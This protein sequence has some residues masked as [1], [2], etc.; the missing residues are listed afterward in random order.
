MANWSDL[1]A[2]VAEV[3]K[4]NGN[5]EITGQVLQNVLNSIISNV[6]QNATFVGV[7]TPT[8]NPGAPDGNVFY[9]AGEGI[10]T[11]FSNLVI[12]TG[13]LGILKWDGT[14]SKQV[15]EIGAGYG[16]MILNWNTDVA[17]TRKQVLQKYRKQL[18]QI[19]YKNGDGDAINEQYI[20]TLLSDEE[21][22]SN[23]NWAK[24]PN[25][26]QLVEIENKA[27][28]DLFGTCEF[29]LENG[30]LTNGYWYNNATGVY[31]N[32]SNTAT[33][34]IIPVEPNNTYDINII[35]NSSTYITSSLFGKNGNFLKG[36]YGTESTI[37]SLVTDSETYGIA[38]NLPTTGSDNPLIQITGD[39]MVSVPFR[40]WE[41]KE[42]Q[43]TKEEFNESINLVKEAT[44]FG[45][46][47]DGGKYINLF[48]NKD[49]S[50]L[51]GFGVYTYNNQNP[52]ATLEKLELD[53]KNWVKINAGTD[54][55]TGYIATMDSADIVAKNYQLTISG[56]SDNKESGFLP[57]SKLKL[58]FKYKSNFNFKLYEIYSGIKTGQK[59]VD[60]QFKVGDGVFS[61]DSPIL[62]N[63]E[64]IHDF[65]CEVY[66][67]TYL[68]AEKTLVYPFG[69]R[70]GVDYGNKV[71][72]GSYIMI[73]DVEIIA[74]LSTPNNINSVYKNRLLTN[75]RISRSE[76]ISDNVNGGEEYISKV[77]GKDWCALGDSY[78]ATPYVM[79]LPI[80]AEKLRLRD[81]RIL[82]VSSSTI[83]TKAA[84]NNFI[85]QVDNLVALKK[86]TGF[87]PH[88]ITIF[89]GTNDSFSTSSS[90]IPETGTWETE[91]GYEDCNSC[92]KSTIYGAT[93][94]ICETLQKEFP[95][96]NVW[97]VSPIPNTDYEH[98]ITL[99]GIMDGVNKM[100]K[101]LG[102]KYFDLL[103][104]SSINIRANFQYLMPY[105]LLH[106]F[107]K[108]HGLTTIA[109]FFTTIVNSNYV[110]KTR[111]RI[112]KIHATANSGALYY[113]N[114]DDYNYYNP[115]GEGCG[116]I[117]IN[118][119]EDAEF[120]VEWKYLAKTFVGYYSDEDYTQLISSEMNTTFVVGNEISKEV[121]AK[122]E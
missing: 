86:S 48:I 34:G 89:G 49:I 82:A 104:E 57:E 114:A 13:Q 20:G 33:T 73:T 119:N 122:F 102:V 29:S 74:D 22:A 4:T 35:V 37:K 60:A 61:S 30:K 100:C 120:S 78:N 117:N 45:T 91:I 7:A 42:Y 106:P 21:W 101:F 1:K 52:K 65:E 58:K 41:S 88:I 90:P 54:Y 23:K 71:T 26:N 38:Y 14:W 70:F 31:E 121:W 105:D 85:Q 17:T 113:T 75:H 87:S 112:L 109:N 94:Y 116:V 66:H 43:A 98:Y 72:E 11:N 39:K 63:D 6:G 9:L 68:Y 108:S 36:G 2:S 97:W 15:L 19:S 103:H 62:E 24:I 67:K 95:F 12:D 3:I 110:E 92:D 51:V 47:S 50:N 76:V 77:I 80:V 83:T 16:N 32:K 27:S 107:G 115:T 25:E 55:I 8:I 64:S 111:V 99:S 81:A 5:Q 40:E 44:E 118:Y 28:I 93:R 18:L 79:W 96:S 69:F 46:A 10:Y 56:D 59:P 84:N 53:N